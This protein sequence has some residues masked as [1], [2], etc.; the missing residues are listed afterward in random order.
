MG[1]VITK[2]DGAR[3]LLNNIIWLLPWHAKG[4][5]GSNGNI[6]V[7]VAHC[8]PRSDHLVSL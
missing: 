7:V 3:E 6:T 8:L 1:F 5:S 4:A 2:E